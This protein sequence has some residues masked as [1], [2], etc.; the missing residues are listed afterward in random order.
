MLALIALLFGLALDPA[1]VKATAE[2]IGTT[3]SQE[4]FDPKVGAEVDAALKRSLADGRYAGAADDQALAALVTRDLYAATHDQHP[5]LLA[6]R[7][8]P[9]ERERSQEQVDASRA[10]EVRRLNAGIR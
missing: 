3:I 5:A 8:V 2:S 6:N 10:L 4:Y 9:A 7:D 1:F